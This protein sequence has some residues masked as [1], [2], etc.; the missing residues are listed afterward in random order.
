VSRVLSYP[1]SGGISK[2]VTITLYEGIKGVFGVEPVDALS[3][4]SGFVAGIGAGG[5]FVMST[6]HLEN[7]LDVT[8]GNAN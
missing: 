3:G 7:D 2:T 6:I 5:R 8:L 1:Q 4:S